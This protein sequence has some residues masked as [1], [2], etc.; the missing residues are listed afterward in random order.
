MSKELDMFVNFL[1][2]KTL[3][4]AQRKIIFFYLSY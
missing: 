4:L 3:K 2:T 1:E